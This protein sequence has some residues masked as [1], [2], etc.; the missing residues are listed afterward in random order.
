MAI[1]ANGCTLR[2]DDDGVGCKMAGGK[3]IG[4]L[5]TAPLVLC[6]PLLALANLVSS[7]AP[8][9]ERLLLLMIYWI[10]IDACYCCVLSLAALYQT[11][12]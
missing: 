11:G 5:C 8:M 7:R 3:S 10:K 9:N 12:A 4:P 6:L 2:Y 1:I